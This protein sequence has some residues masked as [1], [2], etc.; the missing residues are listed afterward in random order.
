[1]ASYQ[2]VKG[3]LMALKEF[4]QGRLPDELRGGGVS[5]G[6]RLLGSADMASSI[7]GNVLALYLH[8]ITVDSHGRNRSFAVRGTDPGLPAPELPVNLHFL[9]MAFGTSASIEADLIGWA[10]L[11]LANDGVLDVSGLGEVDA[12]WADSEICTIAPEDMSTEVLMRIWD[13]FKIPY[14]NS[15]PYVAR[16]VRLRLRS[17]A[18]EGPPVLTRVFPTGAL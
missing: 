7:S 17:P 15:V 8:R 12:G 11:E 1:M 10:M 3:A 4:L 16:S 9:L 18:S 2:G 14:T 6:I 5:A 13:A